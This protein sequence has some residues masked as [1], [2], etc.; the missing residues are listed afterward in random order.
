MLLKGCQMHQRSEE[1]SVVLVAILR[2]SRGPCK[3]TSSELVSTG[4]RGVL[5]RS[6]MLDQLCRH[7]I[8]GL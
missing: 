4:P 8:F 3:W 2:L 6:G 7:G 5:E 1:R